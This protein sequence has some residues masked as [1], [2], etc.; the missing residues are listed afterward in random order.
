M[1]ASGA[2]T[3][4]SACSLSDQQAGFTAGVFVLKYTAQT[5]EPTRPVMAQVRLRRVLP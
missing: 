3:P 1:A 4:A 5:R 2:H